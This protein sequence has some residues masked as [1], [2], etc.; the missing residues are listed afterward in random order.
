MKNKLTLLTTLVL[1]SFS[2]VASKYDETVEP[3][4]PSDYVT[5]ERFVSTA[6]RGA[7]DYIITDTKT[8]CQYIVIDGGGYSKPATSLGCFEEYKKK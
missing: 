6:M 7:L 1:C 3:K 5:Q 2:A 4:M 8:G